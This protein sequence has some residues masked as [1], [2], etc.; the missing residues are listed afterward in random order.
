MSFFHF[1]I[2]NVSLS[3]QCELHIFKYRSH[4][5]FSETSSHHVSL[6]F[7]KFSGLNTGVLN[8][9]VFNFVRELGIGGRGL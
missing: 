8:I 2:L 7:L 9:S 1:L 5:F 6:Y 3:P 4:F